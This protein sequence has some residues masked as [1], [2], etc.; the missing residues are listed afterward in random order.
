[1]VEVTVNLNSSITGITY[2]YESLLIT[3]DQLF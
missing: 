1:M 2:Y 3:A